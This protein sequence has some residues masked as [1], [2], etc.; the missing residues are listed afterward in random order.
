MSSFV[1][2]TP[3]LGV[4]LKNVLLDV[5][6][7]AD[8]SIEAVVDTGYE[9]FLAV[10][11]SVFGKLSLG[12]L[13]TRSRTV[14]VADGRRVRS[15]IGYATVELLGMRQEVDG[16]VETFEGLKEVLVGAKL[17]SSFRVTLDYC[18]R[19]VSLDRCV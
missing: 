18:L 5:S 9:G 7:P 10:P 3:A 4:R 15:R 13:K 16:P 1:G 8:G 17:L 12:E 19:A 11:D 14:E 6:Y 2:L